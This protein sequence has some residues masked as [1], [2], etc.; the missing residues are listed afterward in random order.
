[1]LV[2]SRVEM[3]RS[4]FT[5]QLVL[6][7]VAEV[8]WT[9][10]APSEPIAEYRFRWTPGQ[11]EIPVSVQTAPPVTFLLDTGA[12]YS[13]I[14]T[15]LAQRLQVATERLGIR[16]F[17]DR[18]SLAVSTATLAKGR[19][20][21]LAD[22]RVMVMPF[23]GYRQRGRAIEGLIGYDF[24][25]RYVVQIDFEAATLRVYEPQSFALPSTAS[26]V[27]IEF[28]G[29]VPVVATELEFESRERLDARLMVDTGASQTA[30]LR[31]PFARRHQL[32][33]LAPDGPTR[34]AP[35]LA[36][37]DLKLVRLPARRLHLGVWSF[38]DPYVQAHREPVGSGA[39][40]DTDGVIGNEVLRRFRLTVDYSRR[41][42]GLQPTGR[43]QEPFER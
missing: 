17:A 10:V 16:D 35:S 29:R 14:S 5:I 3:L 8:P 20:I 25:A 12:E 38:D 4:I 36:S 2:R 31:H 18:V 21:R 22:Q 26:R 39:Y 9:R 1:V 13:V 24:F 6:I 37:G 30:I 11:I 19:E 23:D 41:L 15:A 7:A 28:V 27:P 40:S 33:E 42:L 34:I 43:L 32:L